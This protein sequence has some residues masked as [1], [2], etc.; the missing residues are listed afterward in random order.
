[1][2]GKVFTSN[3]IR[4]RRG[5]DPAESAEADVRGMFSAEDQLE[6]QR[7]LG[8]DPESAQRG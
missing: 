7:V 2:A 8:T 5:L 4:K 1:L 3:E 6:R